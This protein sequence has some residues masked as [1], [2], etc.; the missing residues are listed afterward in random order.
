VPI[1]SQWNP[2]GYYYPTQIAQYGLSHYSKYVADERRRSGTEPLTSRPLTRVSVA[3]EDA[4]TPMS[5][6]RWRQSPPT[7]V[8]R[9]VYD[10]T[11]KRN[12]YQF[13]TPGLSDV[14]V[15]SGVAQR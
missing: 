8:L 14:C 1:S 12:V 10:S 3:D 9:R 13:K 6:V 5:G 2:D 15:V 11:V 4:W 7:S